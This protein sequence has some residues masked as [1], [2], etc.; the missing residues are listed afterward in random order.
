MPWKN[1]NGD[2]SET[3]P[4]RVRLPESDTRTAEAVTDEVLADAGWVWEEPVVIV[5]E[6]EVETEVV[7]EYTESTA[8]SVDYTASSS[9]YTSSMFVSDSTASTYVEGFTVSDS[10]ISTI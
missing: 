7:P 1:N 6:P 10:S 8:S 5:Y 9:D 4:T 3:R 2:V